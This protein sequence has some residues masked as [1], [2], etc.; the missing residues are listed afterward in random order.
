LR[1]VLASNSGARRDLF[2]GDVDH[3]DRHRVP[4]VACQ[5]VLD[6][7]RPCDLVY[8]CSTSPAGDEEMWPRTGYRSERGCRRI[9]RR[10]CGC[11]PSRTGSRFAI[12][13]SLALAESTPKRRPR[14]MG[15]RRCHGTTETGAAQSC[16]LSLSHHNPWLF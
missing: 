6:L 9:V 13:D 7:V 16:S 5:V 8:R 12:R 2:V 3:D 14:T 11:R 15:W 10:Y 4:E 1:T